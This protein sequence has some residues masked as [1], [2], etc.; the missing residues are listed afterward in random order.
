[1][2][3]RIPYFLFLLVVFCFLILRT[4]FSAGP[5]MALFTYC[6]RGNFMLSTSQVEMGSIAIKHMRIYQK[7]TSVLNY[8][9][10]RNTLD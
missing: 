5:V 3:F 2:G 9:F 10:W 8:T 6:Y 7:L 4:F 1:M